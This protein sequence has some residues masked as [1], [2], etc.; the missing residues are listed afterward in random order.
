MVAVMVIG[1]LVSHYVLKRR[2]QRVLL[3]G[4]DARAQQQSR[5]MNSSR[6]MFDQSTAVSAIGA[7]RLGVNADSQIN[8]VI[9]PIQVPEQPNAKG[10]ATVNTFSI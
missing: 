5:F 10:F 2:S 9:T 6:Q 3:E 7:S 4:H 8:T 1:S